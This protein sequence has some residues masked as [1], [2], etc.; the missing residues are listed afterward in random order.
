M[1][2]LLVKL[3]VLSLV[4]FGFGFALVPL[5]DV[6]C[7]ITG[8]GGRTNSSAATV[9]EQ[10]DRNRRVRVEF[11]ATVS[12]TAP[13]EFRPT[14]GHID[15]QPGVLTETSFFARNL[16]REGLTG[17]A[18]PSVAP[19]LAAKFFQKTECFCFTPQTFAAGEVKD[20]PVV[21]ILDPQL[22]AHIDTVTLSYT[23]YASPRL[24][25]N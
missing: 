8:F 1:R 23:F 10:P 3:A 11:V 25:R 2:Y 5:Y 24:A 22:P 13:W 20:M 14:V 15:V 6:F 9:I 16:A 7:Q 12:P 18:T 4:M 19:G 21:F 17:H